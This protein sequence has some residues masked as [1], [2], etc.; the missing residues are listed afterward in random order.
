MPILTTPAPAVA[1]GRPPLLAAGQTRPPVTTPPPLPPPPQGY[2][3]TVVDNVDGSG[4]ETVSLLRM[5]DGFYDVWVNSYDGVP[6][7]GNEKIEVRLASG[8]GE[9]SVTHESVYLIAPRQSA[10]GPIWWHAGFINR[11]SID[12]GDAYTPNTYITQ[13]VTLDAYGSSPEGTGC[14]IYRP[15]DMVK[16][17]ANSSGG[18]AEL[19]TGI[20]IGVNPGALSR[21]AASVPVEMSATQLLVPPADPPPGG[22]FG[23]AV[24]YLEPSGTVFAPPGVNVS[25]PLSNQLPMDSPRRPGVFRLENGGW[26]EIASE[27]IWTPMR[28]DMMFIEAS[29]GTTL[30]FSAYALII[31]DKPILTTTTTSVIVTTTPPPRELP[32]DLSKAWYMLYVVYPL[33]GIVGLSVLM[34]CC[35]RY[36]YGYVPC[37]KPPAP[38]LLD[39]DFAPTKSKGQHTLRLKLLERENASRDNY[40]EV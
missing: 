8:D 6:F 9:T 13:F 24:I 33:S 10:P 31:L 2:L 1:T 15:T 11:T 32:Q 40:T 22:V 37:Y 35:F 18:S 7:E 26:Q 39:P 25:F 5:P 19:A 28:N 16:F 23:Q 17:Y 4:P 3:E 21:R 34:A 29:R 36:R 30:R 14:R 20:S 27:D 38:D 12:N